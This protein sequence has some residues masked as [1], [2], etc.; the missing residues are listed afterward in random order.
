LPGIWKLATQGKPDSWVVGIYALAMAGAGFR[1]SKSRT[2]YWLVKVFSG[3]LVGLLISLGAEGWIVLLGWCFGSLFSDIRYFPDTERTGELLLILGLPL[4]TASTIRYLIYRT[5]PFSRL[6]FH[7][8]LLEPFRKT[9]FYG[10]WG[11]IR[12]FERLEEVLLLKQLTLNGYLGGLLMLIILVAAL[13][14]FPYQRVGLLP[15]FA[16]SLGL[17]AAAT[18]N[19]NAV[20]VW[21]AILFPLFLTTAVAVSESSNRW[22]FKIV[23]FFSLS[24]SVLFC[25]TVING[26][27]FPLL[28]RYTPLRE[29]TVRWRGGIP[30]P[31]FPGLYQ[32]DPMHQ[33]LGFVGSQIEP[34]A[35]LLVDAPYAYHTCL[36]MG[37]KTAIVS[38][39]GKSPLLLANKYNSLLYRNKLTPRLLTKLLSRNVPVYLLTDDYDLAEKEAERLKV[40]M[41]LYLDVG[42][43]NFEVYRLTNKT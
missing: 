22:R 12:A 28:G 35:W 1:Y 16:V 11:A 31:K 33:V 29:L 7:R 18:M 36:Q 19:E 23:S 25:L 2:V 40:E 17:I 21:P 26:Q 27:R 41:N 4:L 30:S 15:P 8:Y 14:Y 10:D 39:V 24:L 38:Y 20:P 37:M 43:G 5:I 9:F 32:A 6:P 3:L 34:G 42:F 13:L